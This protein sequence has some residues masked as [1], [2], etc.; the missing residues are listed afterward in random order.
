MFVQMSWPS[1]ST[2]RASIMQNE[3][4]EYP[5]KHEHEVYLLHASRPDRASACCENYIW[6]P[7]RGNN[8]AQACGPRS[9]LRSKL[10]TS[11]TAYLWSVNPTHL[12]RTEMRCLGEDAYDNAAHRQ[13]C[14]H[15]V[16]NFLN[17]KF[18]NSPDTYYF[19]LRNTCLSVFRNHK[20]SSI[21]K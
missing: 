21:S 14:F 8:F 19:G 12:F 2:T 4:V 9:S 17:K 5:R 3:V 20:C 7:V 13:T 16:V 6:V 18:R 11:H 1:P 10:L 15:S